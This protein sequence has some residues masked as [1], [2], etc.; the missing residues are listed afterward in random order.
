MFKSCCRATSAG[1]PAC[2]AIKADVVRQDETEKALRA[3]LN[4]GHTLGHAIEKVAG[5]GVYLH[6]EA[7]A[8][9]MVYAALLSARLRGLPG[10]EVDRIRNLLLALGLPVSRPEVSWPALRAAMTLDKKSARARP[11]FVLA[12]A[13]GKVAWG[14]EAS[15]EVLEEVWRDFGSTPAKEAHHV[16]RQ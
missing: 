9:G 4:F 2:C 8:L 6:G 5:Y 16:V 7:V 11:R 12:E 13:I 15:D 14:C 10:A 1:V 3:I